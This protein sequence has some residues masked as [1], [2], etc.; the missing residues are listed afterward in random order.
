MRTLL[1]AGTILGTVVATGA[2]SMQGLRSAHAAPDAPR[3]ADP[4]IAHSDDR[5]TRRD[6]CGRDVRHHG[7]PIDLEVKGADVQDVLRLIADAGRVNIVLSDE[8][9][10]K[11]TLKLTRVPW[12]AAACAIA[13]VHRLMITVDGNVLLVTPAARAQ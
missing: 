5:A 1:V 9:A 8:V 4:R 10:G 2:P 3:V 13:A 6:L 7:A 11:V 12:D